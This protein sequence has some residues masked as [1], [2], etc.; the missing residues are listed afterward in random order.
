VTGGL[1]PAEL[2]TVTA[3]TAPLVRYLKADLDRIVT[4]ANE[5]IKKIR[6]AGL[7]DTERR[8]QEAR[9]IND[10]RSFAV[11]RVE[12]S[13]RQLRNMT[14]KSRAPEQPVDG[15]A[16]MQATP[17]FQLAP[18]PPDIPDTPESLTATTELTPADQSGGW[19]NA[20]DG[21]DRDLV[22]A[23]TAAEQPDTGEIT[24]GR[25]THEAATADQFTS[26]DTTEFTTPSSLDY[27]EAAQVVAAD[28]EEYT[29]LP[30]SDE[31]TEIEVP[32]P[33]NP[34]ETLEPP[35]HDTNTELALDQ[36]S[37]LAPDDT[38]ALEEI[39]NLMQEFSTTLDL[40]P[41]PPRQ[42]NLPVPPVSMFE[43]SSPAAAA[44]DPELPYRT[45]AAR[46][47]LP[48]PPSETRAERL[49]RL[50]LFVARQ[51]PE[52]RWAVGIRRDDTTVLVTDIAH[53]WIPPGIN[54]PADVRLL[55]P[56][57]R[58][59]AVDVLLGE[60]E[61]SAT[62]SPGD[63]LGWAADDDITATSPQ[64][65]A[66]PA[67]DDLGWVLSDATHWRE[68]LP[69]MVSTLAKAAARG[70]GV[71]AAERDV[72]SAY[73]DTARH[74]LFAQ[75]PDVD[76]AL[77]LNCLLLAAAE[78]LAGNDSFSANYHLAWFEKLNSPDAE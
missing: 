48:P 36:P 59:G 9:V 38:Q 17:R 37:P 24:A 74:Q 63:P 78:S 55:E 45:E 13:V 4:S 34:P 23:E 47:A 50:V 68:G 69:R 18:P 65:R 10:A 21:S 73:L 58:D 56:G 52:L 42:P 6:C 62:Y 35:P 64:P 39:A 75:Y 51:E 22:P 70:T 67:I 3:E 28:A 33:S 66:L 29:D 25:T 5:E 46:H 19:Q 49:E 12:S 27:A 77:L 32:R 54:L 43:P 8:A 7:V 41:E 76:P 20:G 11:R 53:G 2:S 1:W 16:E 31:T 40:P 26:D 72:L 61:L 57:R 15:A 14:T 71:A 30:D 60:T 44:D